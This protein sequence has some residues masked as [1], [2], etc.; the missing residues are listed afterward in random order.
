MVQTFS[1]QPANTVETNFINRTYSRSGIVTP[2]DPATII[3]YYGETAT[4]LWVGGAGNVVLESS[5]GTY[6]FFQG[7]AA[8][9]KL[10]FKHVRVLTTGTVGG[11]LRT[12]TATLMT[13]MGGGN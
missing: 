7:I 13:W 12:T 2:A 6:H 5:D 4:A 8:G 3:G 11:L 9:T 1:T 10:E